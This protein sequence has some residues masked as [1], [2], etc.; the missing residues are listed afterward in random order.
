MHSLKITQI[1][2]SLGVILPY[3]PALDEQLR[4]GR[5]FMQEYRDTF[6]QRPMTRPTSPNWRLAMASG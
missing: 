3:D 1:G 2:N 6:R 4:L 5:E